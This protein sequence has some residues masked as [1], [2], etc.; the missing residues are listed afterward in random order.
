MNLPA[1]VPQWLKMLYPKRI[2]QMDVHEKTL[3][4]SFDDGP[5][6][7][8]TPQVLDI[9][10][11]NRAKATFFCLGK[12]VLQHPSIFER[13]IAEGHAVGNHSH[14]HLNGWKSTDEEYM[15]DVIA[16]SR[17]IP[18][19]LFRPPYGRL[20]SS[21]ARRLQAVGFKV[22]MWGVLSADYNKKISK[23]KCAVRVSKHIEPGAIVLFHDSE[24]AANN[25]LHAL[26]MLL[27]NATEQG[28]RFEAMPYKK[29]SA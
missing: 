27:K 19:N 25:M 23:E 14:H 6:E 7:I 8:I 1:R 11:K 16:A 24:K 10:A 13:I 17:W 5:H 4:I 12:N 3:F 2:W 9:L 26:E 20:K 15:D 28:F 22:V 21:Q 29:G 18:S